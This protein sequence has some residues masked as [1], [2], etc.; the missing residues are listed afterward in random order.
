MLK[1]RKCRFEK[2]N[3]LKRHKNQLFIAVS[4]ETLWLSV[5]SENFDTFF[6]C[7]QLSSLFLA[8]ASIMWNPAAENLGKKMFLSTTQCSFFLSPCCLDTFDDRG[9]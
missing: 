2:K 3:D 4:F 5:S 6:L 9:M 7:K 8:K 1:F